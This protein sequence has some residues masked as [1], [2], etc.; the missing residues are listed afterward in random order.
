MTVKG[1][2]RTSQ[3]WHY[4][5]LNI[6]MLPKDLYYSSKTIIYLKWNDD[7]FPGHK[8]QSMAWVQNRWWNWLVGEQNPHTH[9]THF[10]KNL[11]ISFIFTEFIRGVTKNVLYYNRLLQTFIPV[12]LIFIFYFKSVNSYYF[13]MIFEIKLK[14]KY[15]ISY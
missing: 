15:M 5:L 14:I 3:I 1:T 13:K 10:F 9:T 8:G 4:D 12:F 7:L 11:Q 2:P 6:T